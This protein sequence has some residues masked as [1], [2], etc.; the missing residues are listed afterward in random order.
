MR[1]VRVYC[2]CLNEI[3]ATTAP[4]NYTRALRDTPKRVLR[5]Y[6]LTRI[7]VEFQENICVDPCSSV[8]RL[9]NLLRTLLL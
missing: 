2:K 1:Q 3:E 6:E 9:L 4:S 5:K 8:T 7:A